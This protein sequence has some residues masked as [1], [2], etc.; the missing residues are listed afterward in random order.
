MNPAFLPYRYPAARPA[1]SATA[2]AI[3]A[4]PIQRERFESAGIGVTPVG[5]ETP[6][7]AS[8]S[9]AT[10]RADS[11]RSSGF[12]SRQWRTI[13]SSPGWMSLFVC[14]RSGGSFDR[15]AVI[16]SAAVSPRN[17]R[18]PDSIS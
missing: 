18:W 16:V 7:R 1:A 2:A 15:I 8:R 4:G 12:F 5:V 6:E 17:A 10:S 9:K 13:R 11:N 14:E 3:S